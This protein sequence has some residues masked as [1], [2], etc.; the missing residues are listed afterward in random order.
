MKKHLLT[1]AFCVLGLA[2]MQAQVIPEGYYYIRSSYNRNYV[3]DNTG[4]VINNGNNIEIYQFYGNNAQK[5]HVTHNNGAIVIRSVIN[6]NYVID[7]NGGFINNGNNIQLWE[8]NGSNAQRWY[9]EKRGDYYVLHSAANQ[10]YNLDLNGC[11][12]SNG[13]NI[14]LWEENGNMAQKWY[15][16]RI[17]QPSYTTI[18]EGT[19]YIRSS[20]N[21]NYVIDLNGGFINNGNNIQIW[22]FNGSNAQKW[23][24]THNNGAIVLRNVG[25]PNFV[26]DLYSSNAYYRQNINLWEYNGSNAQRWYAE[27]RGAY[28]VLHSAVNKFFCLD[29][30]GTNTS[31]G[32]NIHLWEDNNTAAQ[33]WIFESVAPTVKTTSKTDKTTTTP[34]PTPAPTTTA[35]KQSLENTAQPQPTKHLKYNG[36]DICVKRSDFQK[37][38][39]KGKMAMPYEDK[40]DQGSMYAVIVDAFEKSEEIYSNVKRPSTENLYY[41]IAYGTP[42]TDVVYGITVLINYPASSLKK[43]S[44]ENIKKTYLL[45]K[46]NLTK[47]YG[48][49]VEVV[50]NFQRPYSETNKPIEAFLKDKAE[51]YCVFDAKEAGYIALSIDNMAMENRIDIVITTNYFDAVGEQLYEQEK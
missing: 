11:N 35:P 3:V 7:L 24:V 25:N 47:E 51:Y 9:P 5:W 43:E 10:H 29:L 45:R 37:T 19:Y 18:P 22:E 8:Y 36:H 26:I 27:K 42:K 15:F 46:E 23:K 17:P 1:F 30:N 50:K 38:V 44:W 49:P 21:R 20:A 39:L 40:G 33:K 13:E 12:T 48:K 14:H 6:E 31:N 32:E 2:I 16:E 28:Y 34:T 4:F 41:I